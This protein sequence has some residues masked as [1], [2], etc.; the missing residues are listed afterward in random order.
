[1]DKHGRN[2]KLRALAALAVG[3]IMLASARAARAENELPSEMLPS[4]M[5]ADATTMDPDFDTTPP[6]NG[7]NST[8]ETTTRWES[9]TDEFGETLFPPL[10]SETTT[11]KPTTTKATTTTKKT[12]TYTLPPFEVNPAHPDDTYTG[13]LWYRENPDLYENTVAQATRPSTTAPV[14]TTTQEEET[15]PDMQ[16]YD[17]SGAA[18]RRIVLLGAG[19]L[20]AL[21]ALVVVI[22]LFKGRKEAREEEQRVRPLMQPTPPP[23]PGEPKP[24]EE[25]SAAKPGEP[26]PVEE[27]P[28]SKPGEPEPIEEIS[29][30]KPGEPEPVEEISAAKPGEPELVEESVRLVDEI[31]RRR[32]EH[33]ADIPWRFLDLKPPEA[34][35][36]EG[37]D[38]PE[39]KEP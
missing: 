34:A 24:V 33:G 6:P 1:M 3:V 13:P 8:T 25:I 17:D 18:L 4:S 22:L 35:A 37:K 39:T 11:K 14:T 29:A 38:P 31:V 27:T 9:P 30:T 36:P 7:E 20:L 16:G 10:P 21:A 19:A 5:A 26:A 32:R 12:T 23:K 15:F 2:T 28:A